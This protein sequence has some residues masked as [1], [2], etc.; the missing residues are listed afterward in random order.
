MSCKISLFDIEKSRDIIC[1]IP[2]ILQ[3]R[4]LRPERWSDLPEVT[5]WLGAES[6]YHDSQ[7]PVQLITP[8]SLSNCHSLCQPKWTIRPPGQQDHVNTC[9]LFYPS[10]LDVTAQFHFMET[11][12][13]ISRADFFKA[14]K[15]KNHQQAS[16]WLP[17]DHLIQKT[18]TEWAS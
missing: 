17:R 9:H 16:G 11:T 5:I 18:G 7:P 14:K 4:E 8:H 15:G 6:K 12:C 10:P 13:S 3:I 2:L 1:T